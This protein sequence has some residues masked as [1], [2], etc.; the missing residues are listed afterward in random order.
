MTDADDEAVMVVVVVEIDVS[1]FVVVD[2]VAYRPNPAAAT[3]IRTIVAIAKI[4]FETA[5]LL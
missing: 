1:V 5:S 3:M 4:E 2:W